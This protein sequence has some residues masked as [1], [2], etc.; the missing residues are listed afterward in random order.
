V[1]VDVAV[2]AGAL[3]VCAKAAELVSVNAAKYK[4]VL[5]I[6]I[7]PPDIQN[8][9]YDPAATMTPNLICQLC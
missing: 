1:V 8:S 2:G 9:F 3:D 5:V 4:L 6:F 7:I